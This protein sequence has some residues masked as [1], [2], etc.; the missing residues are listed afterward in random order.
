MAFPYEI[1]RTFQGHNSADVSVV[2]L[3][4]TNWIWYEISLVLSKGAMFLMRSFY[5]LIQRENHTNPTHM[6]L[7]I[8]EMLNIVKL[9]IRETPH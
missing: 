7:S 4:K 1:K 2:S 8:R 6:G 9:P 3:R 5:R